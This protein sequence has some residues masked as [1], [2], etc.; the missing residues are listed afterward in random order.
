MHV[1][2]NM[3]KDIVNA[4]V[5]ELRR[6]YN[7]YTVLHSVAEKKNKR[8]YFCYNYVKLTPNLIIFGTT[9]GNGRQL[10]DVHSFSTSR[11]SR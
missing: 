8:N 11:N 10:Y 2:I 3:A 1:S 9:M 6:S 5:A 7:L 4:K